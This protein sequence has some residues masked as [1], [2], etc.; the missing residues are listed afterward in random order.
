MMIR[1]TGHVACMGEKRCAYSVLVDKAKG[2]RKLVRPMHKLADNIKKNLK[3]I[4]WEGMEWINL[5]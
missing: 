4:G 1:Q 5:A 3:E 2:K